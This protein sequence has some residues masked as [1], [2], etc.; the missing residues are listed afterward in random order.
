VADV[1]RRDA[2]HRREAEL[3]AAHGEEWVGELAGFCRSWRF[4]RG[5]VRPTMDARRFVA[6]RFT[7][8]APELF[9]RAWVDGVRLVRAES[10]I[11]RVAGVPHLTALRSLSLSGNGLY[12]EAVGFLAR[13]PG[14]SR[15]THLDL[16]GNRIGGAGLLP[17]MESPGL[18]RLTWLD[19]RHNNLGG[20]GRHSVKRLLDSPLGRRLRRLDLDGN[21]LGEDAERAYAD[22]RRERDG[23]T[24]PARFRNALGMELVL[25]PAGSFLMGSPDGEAGRNDDEGP[26]HEVEIT[27][28]FYLGV[29]HVTQRQYARLMGKDPSHFTRGELPPDVDLARLP[30]DSVAPDD[31]RRFCERLS[32]LPDERAAG[33]VY[34][35]ATEAEWEHACRAGA[36]SDWPFAFGPAVSSHQA[37]FGGEEPYGDAPKGPRLGR[38]TP[39]GVYEANA[40]GLYDMHGNMWDWVA[41]YYAADYYEHSPRRDP[42]GPKADYVSV[43]K[44]G[45]WFNGPQWCRSAARF[46]STNNSGS[47]CIGFRVAMDAGGP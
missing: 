33:R 24:R 4:D 9:R 26:R 28:P 43:L 11:E 40:F 41:D 36:P 37:N 35:L 7:R 25:I 13:S 39:G 30:V 20:S 42:P 23:G 47:Y 1:H 14:L 32:Q 18:E 8:T 6:R 2:M 45:S 21:G 31:C 46:G 5:L 15:L 12:N 17:L 10:Y 34:R 16:S 38:P 22:W 19:L 44:G 29:G 3:L 27:R